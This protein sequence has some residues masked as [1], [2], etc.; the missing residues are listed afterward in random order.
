MSNFITKCRVLLKINQFAISIANFLLEIEIFK[1][2]AEKK[3][4]FETIFKF[5]KNKN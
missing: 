1:A 2:F 5:C 4:I 3:N